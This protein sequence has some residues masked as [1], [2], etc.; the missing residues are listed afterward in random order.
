MYEVKKSQI[1]AYVEAV[2]KLKRTTKDEDKLQKILKNEHYYLNIRD[3]TL[4]SN[5]IRINGYQQF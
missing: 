3:I 2:L 1:S 4:K 5:T